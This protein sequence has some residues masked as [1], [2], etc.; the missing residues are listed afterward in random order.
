[1]PTVSATSTLLLA[2]PLNWLLDRIPGINKIDITLKDVQ[3][4]LGFFGDQMILGLIL[5]SAIG[6]LGWVQCYSF[7][8]TRGKYVCCIGYY[9]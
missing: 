7:L 4:Y 3:K 1:M 2:W 8:A 5:G 9:S 6:L